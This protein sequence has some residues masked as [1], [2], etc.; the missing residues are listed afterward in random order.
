MADTSLA[1]NHGCS[2]REQSKRGHNNLNNVITG[3]T[4]LLSTKAVERLGL[5]RYTVW[6][7]DIVFLYGKGLISNC[8]P[9]SP[10]PKEIETA[11]SGLQHTYDP[12]YQSNTRYNSM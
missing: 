2:E 6:H 8:V 4:N 5:L 12:Y 7:L 9:I 11:V 10:L 3:T 1:F